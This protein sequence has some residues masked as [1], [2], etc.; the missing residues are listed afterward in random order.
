MTDDA[1]RAGERFGGLQRRTS[2]QDR[3]SS[4]SSWFSGEQEPVPGQDAPEPP[5]PQPATP[6]PP[7]QQ[8][9]QRPSAEQRY[10]DAIAAMNE[11]V[12]T[13]DFTRLPW[14]TEVFRVTAGVLPEGD[15]ARAGVLNNLGSAAQLSHLRTG[16]LEDLDDAIAYY[17]SAAT[18]AREEDRDLVLYRCNLALALGDLA[19][20]T[21]QRGAALESARV[22]REAVRGTSARDPRRV[23]ALIRLATALSQ[24]ARLAADTASDEESID[25]LRE[26]VRLSPAREPGTS[27]LLINLGGALLRRYE[28]DGRV[29][30]LD[31]AI[32]HLGSGA[33]ALADGE[34]R[35]DALCR[36][37]HA[38][39]LRFEHSGDLADLEAAIG[40][41]L[42][43]L[44]VLDAGHPLLGR[45]VRHLAV[46]TTAHVDATGEPTQLRRVLRP[47]APAVRALTAD[48]E[49]RAVGLSAYGTLLRRHY[50]HGGGAQALDAAVR[51]GQSALAADPAGED[52]GRAL[53]ALAG[54]LVDRFGVVG[55]VADLEQ[56]AELCEQVSEHVPADSPL[57]LAADAQRGIVAVH[58]HEATGR[59]RELDAAIELLDRTLEALPESA[60]ERAPA[61]IQL[62]RAL[63]AVH[64]RTGRRRYYRWARKVLTEAA[65]QATAPADQRL[66]AAALAGRLAAQGQRWAEAT[67]SLGT[68]VGLL[69]LVTRGKRVVASAAQQQ[70]W[71][72]ITADAAACAVESGDPERAVELVEQGREAILA[73]YLPTGGELGILHRTHP[74]LADEAVRLRRLLDRPV[75]EP[76]DGA[77]RVRLVRAWEAL[78]AEAREVQPNHLRRTAFADLAGGAED[79]LAVLLNLSRY[80]SDALVLIGGRVLLVPLPA[81]SPESAAEQSAALLTAAQ[82]GDARTA[83]D[84]LDWTWR[85]VVR[86]VLDRM[87]YLGTPRERWPRVWW[88]AFGEAAYLP[89]H[90]AAP[91]GGEGAL[92]RVVSSSTPTL[93]C[94]LRAR[95]RPLPEGGNPLVAAGSANAVSWELPRQNQVLAQRWPGAE[96]ASVESTHALE[97]LRMMPEHPWLHVCEPSSQFPSRP[98]AGLVLDREPPQRSVGAVELG[99]VALDRSEFAYLGRCA[100]AAETPSAAAT[101]LAAVL[102]FAGFT[103]VIGSL[104]DVEQDCGA[105]VHADVY[106]E[107]FG[108]DGFE[109]DG[110]AYAL[111]GA[112]QRV[113]AEFPGDPT[114]WAGH[115]HVGP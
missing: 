56:A 65:E 55:E 42:G 52:R 105:Q 44:G 7:P 57:R 64:H 51:A 92:D 16:D 5:A 70:R 30:D 99:Q 69:P 28:R 58:R 67:E 37:A 11:I 54:S 22:A 111:H 86:P 41:L 73:D 71:A 13:L 115:V 84:V 43:V 112:A 68:A 74:D 31:D 80:R 114:R 39:R 61:A 1:S 32:K 83:T 4:G 108:S 102:G 77:D 27:D 34:P 79:G 24:H 21:D 94:L 40:E 38:Q 50:Q 2:G 87:G 98:A 81:A 19:A 49:E 110:S 60:P 97:L 96:I 26:A 25:V 101:T 15:P 89:L 29:E 33:D 66:R 10:A 93:S 104:W 113:R 85:S 45:A 12:A 91:R 9:G 106:A 59:S 72:A 76:G 36:L 3:G 95:S 8:G 47:I 14:V 35:R 88:S 82:Q 62:G 109:T 17:R 46:A 23:M 103:H 6:P 48:D 53:C 75:G 107:V 100:T 18:G 20:K 90:A 63:R 78:L